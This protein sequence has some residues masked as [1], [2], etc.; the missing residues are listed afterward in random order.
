M[1]K[2]FKRLPSVLLIFFLVFAFLAYSLKDKIVLY[3]IQKIAQSMLPGLEV[4][5]DGITV[6]SNF[7]GVRQFDLR[8]T[9]KTFS[10]TAVKEARASA[11][12]SILKLR[13]DQILGIAQSHIS[14]K[15]VNFSGFVFDAFLLNCTRNPSGLWLDA[16]LRLS[17]LSQ[18]DKQIKDVRATLKIFPGAVICDRLEMLVLG[19]KISGRGR[20]VFSQHSW[21][22]ELTLQLQGIRMEDLMKILAMEKRVEASGLYDGSLSI[23]LQDS[24]IKDLSG[25]LVSKSGGKF[26]ITDPS[27]LAGDLG[28]QGSVNI[29]VE[30]L[31]NYYYDIGNVKIRN[32]AQN[33]KIGILL[34]GQAGAR[35]LDVFWHSQQQ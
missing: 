10:G 32:E 2:F 9:R 21:Q 15:E 20:I 29:V 19:G 4:R 27:L 16:F 23:V 7:F 11:K 1:Q 33:I 28:G 30:N 35:S 12:F 22:L 17:A 3:A 13:R 24:R 14:A 34:S 8:E 18:G 6:S 25:E 31:T 26:L 5:I